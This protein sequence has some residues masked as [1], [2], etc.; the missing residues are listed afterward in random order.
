MIVRIQIVSILGSLGLLLLILEL[1]RRRKLAERYSLLWIVTALVLFGLS[2]WRGLLH[3]FARA[4]GIYDPPNALFLVGF[5][6]VLLLI[7]HFSVIVSR[8]SRRSRELAQSLALLKRDIEEMSR[9][10]EGD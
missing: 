10:G 6:F 5:V 8:L 7:L 1:I 3:L 2:V 9:S 4:V